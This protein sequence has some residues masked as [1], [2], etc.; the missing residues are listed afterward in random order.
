MS[1][2]LE[3][4]P[5]I[6]TLLSDGI[7]RY[8]NPRHSILKTFSLGLEAHDENYLSRLL[9]ALIKFLVRM[10][11]DIKDG[12]LAINV[13]LH[14]IITRAELIDTSSRTTS[15]ANSNPTFTVT[16]RIQNLCINNRPINDPQRLMMYLKSVDQIIRN[17]FKYQE[18]ELLKVIPLITQLSPRR[19][20]DLDRLIALM[21]NVSPIK[22][23]EGAGFSK[24]GHRMVGPHLLGNQQLLVI[25]KAPDSNQ[26]ENL[27]GQEFVLQPSDLTPK[28]V[29]NEIVF[30][31]FAGT[32]ERSI[33]HQVLVT[34]RDLVNR[35]GLMARTRRSN[36]IKDIISQLELIR[37]DVVKG[38]YDGDDLTSATSFIQLLETFNNWLVNPYL[39]LLSLSCRNMSAILNVC[40]ANN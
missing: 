40:E 28:A 8:N 15:R 35:I 16:T 34:S 23:A 31:V 11:E 36:R 21:K 7:E 14:R 22:F 25:S 6:P 5:F 20:G 12:S 32:T 38:N 33:I 10:M 27:I 3:D 17:Y 37:N 30:N 9:D 39:N 26:I 29:P 1:D 18:E 4:L 19:P 24:D 13:N 2:T